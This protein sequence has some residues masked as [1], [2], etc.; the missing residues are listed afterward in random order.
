MATACVTLSLSPAARQRLAL[1]EN[2]LACLDVVFWRANVLVSR[3]DG[4]ETGT[5]GSGFRSYALIEDTV[6]PLTPT[7]ADDMMPLAS[8]RR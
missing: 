3:G 7:V 2:P 5:D 6:T 8:N 4:Y 1:Q